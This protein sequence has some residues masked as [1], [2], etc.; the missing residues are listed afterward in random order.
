MRLLPGNAQ[1][2]TGQ[3]GPLNQIN[4]IQQAVVHPLAR[5]MLEHSTQSL[6]ASAQLAQDYEAGALGVKRK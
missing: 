5:S 2:I 4:R 3:R 6:E 1:L